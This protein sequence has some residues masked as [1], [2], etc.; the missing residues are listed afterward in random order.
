[1]ED[2]R[3]RAKFP[4]LVAD[5]VDE[6]RSLDVVRWRCKQ[7][8]SWNWRGWN[9]LIGGIMVELINASGVG[10]KFQFPRQFQK[11]AESSS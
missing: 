2:V 10:L 6:Y 9:L 8:E 1:M 5:L 3:T 11:R 7:C 4:I